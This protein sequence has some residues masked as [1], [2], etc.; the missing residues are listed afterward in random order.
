MSES[1]NI[2]TEGI[3]I[4]GDIGSAKPS[5]SKF[6]D[7]SKSEDEKVEIIANIAKTIWKRIIIRKYNWSTSY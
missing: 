2:I 5:L 1:Y 6:C 4:G 3:H 7:D